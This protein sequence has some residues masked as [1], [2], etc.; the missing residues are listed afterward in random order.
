MT[1]CLRRIDPSDPRDRTDLIA[2]M[3][4][5][6]FPCHVR[7]RPTTWQVEEGIRRGDYRSADNDSYWLELD[8]S[9]RV[10][11]L[12]FQDLSDGGPTFDLRLQTRWRGRRLAVG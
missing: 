12:R 7:P 11:F 2:F 3:T 5:H 8:G 1:L 4:G 6:V 10:G 9:T